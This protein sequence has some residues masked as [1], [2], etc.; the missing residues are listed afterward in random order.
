MNKY[1]AVALLL[2]TSGAYAKPHKHKKPEL[3]KHTSPRHD[4]LKAGDMVVVSNMYRP[5]Y[6]C[7]GQIAR[8]LT[9]KNQIW[10]L[11]DIKKCDNVSFTRLSQMDRDE[12]M[13]VD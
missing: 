9:R 13:L 5:Q 3:P 4:N 8:V 6:G 11:V 10:Y 2:L 12:L 7:G 1:I